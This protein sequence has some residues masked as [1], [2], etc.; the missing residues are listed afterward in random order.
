MV[1][2]R[3]ILMKV[4]KYFEIHPAE[5]L[6]RGSCRALC[7][8]RRGRGRAPASGELTLRRSPD[9]VVRM[10]LEEGPEIPDPR[11]KWSAAVAIAVVLLAGLGTGLWVL[12]RPS[13]GP[14]PPPDVPWPTAGN[15]SVYLCKS[16]GAEEN[17]RKRAITAA[18]RL[19]V[20]R[21]LRSLPEVSGIRFVSR[22]EALKAFTEVYVRLGAALGESDM[23]ESFRVDLTT[24]GGF[25]RKVEALPGVS[26]VH[27]GGTNFWSG[28][29]DVEV[30]L[31]SQ[32][33]QEDSRCAGRGEATAAEKDAVYQVLRALDGVGA[34][35][36]EDRGHASRNSY[37][38]TFAK[39]QDTTKPDARIP[40][41]FHLVLDAPEAAE[42]VKR[43]VGE[44]RCGQRRQGVL[45]TEG[46][47]SWAQAVGTSAIAG[48]T[49]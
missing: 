28:K 44:F 8:L 3:E 43:A 29:T 10:S 41:S 26:G 20:D 27:V 45:L 14:L 42:R 19:T 23:P 30:R 24:T 31:C 49:P 38:M 15:A 32:D 39:S 13:A 33:V 47:P 17:C 4:P 9:K 18:Q 37:W 7:D 46:R 2:P 16:D 22:A 40:E 6:L 48:N 5:G 1:W 25:M 21:T 35:Y 36:L 12:L 11:G 34:V